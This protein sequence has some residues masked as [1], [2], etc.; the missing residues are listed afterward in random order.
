[1]RHSHSRVLGLLA[2]AVQPVIGVIDHFLVAGVRATST[3]AINSN[4]VSKPIV[5]VQSGDLVCASGER[6]ES[7][8]ALNDLLQAVSRIV[9]I[10]RDLAVGIGQREPIAD[11]VKGG[12]RG[13][14]IATRDWRG[15]C[16]LRQAVLAIISKGPGVGARGWARLG[17]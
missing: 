1:M 9:L 3:G 10:A 13:Q 2:D 11:R 12:R 6:I 7:V 15:S 16:R 4:Q 17:C 8:V 5:A 14:G